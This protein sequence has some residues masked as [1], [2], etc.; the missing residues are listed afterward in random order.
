M[1]KS[2]GA[3][4]SPSNSASVIQRLA[5]RDYPGLRIG[6]EPTTDKFVAVCKGDMD[7]AEGCLP[8]DMTLVKP[9]HGARQVIPGNALVVDKSMPFTQLS[10]FGREA[11]TGE[12]LSLHMQ[13]AA[14]LG[15]ETVW[16]EPG[17]ATTF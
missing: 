9:L 17:K 12:L 5:R 8:S 16:L 4:V 14:E 6:P 10:H 15:A 3:R 13:S 7:Q 1:R 2:A 11:A